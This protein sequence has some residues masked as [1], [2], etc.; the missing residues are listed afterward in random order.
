MLYIIDAYLLGDKGIE[1]QAALLIQLHQSGR[2]KMT[3]H[4][5]WTWRG[6]KGRLKDMSYMKSM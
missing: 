1:V 3:S 5:E 6:G 4:G 2:T